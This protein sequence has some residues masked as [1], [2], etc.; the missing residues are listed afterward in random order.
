MCVDCVFDSELSLEKAFSSPFF[1]FVFSFS[2]VIARSFLKSRALFMLDTTLSC[3]VELILAVSIITWLSSLLVSLL[4]SLNVMGSC[5]G[6]APMGTFSITELDFSRFA[7]STLCSDI[8]TLASFGA[9]LSF[10]LDC[11]IVFCVPGLSLFTTLF[12][13]SPTLSLNSSSLTKTDI[14]SCLVCIVDDVTFCSSCTVF[15]SSLF[16]LSL[17]QACEEF[18]S[19][20][21]AVVAITLDFSTR[22]TTLCFCSA[23]I[24]LTVW[25]FCSESD[26]AFG[27]TSEIFSDIVITFSAP[28]S[29]AKASWSLQLVCW[30]PSP[31]L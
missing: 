8:L 12:S 31:E 19:L 20:L 1:S 2:V 28:V 11:S 6:L 18:I 24:E 14:D 29:T 25:G 15:L 16:T 5:F 9:T 22:S 13:A 27:V 17:L 4:P 3:S 7:L 10:A 21:M 30:S 26:A 23:I